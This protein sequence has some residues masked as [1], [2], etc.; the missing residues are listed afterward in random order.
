M[1]IILAD[2]VKEGCPTLAELQD[3]AQKLDKWNPLRRHLLHMDES[4]IEHIKKIQAYTGFEPLTS[5]ILVQFKYMTFIYSQS[6]IHHFTGLFDTNIMSSSQ[7][8]C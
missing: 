4:K 5:P 1:N 3:L 6:F 8:A 2:R 7:W